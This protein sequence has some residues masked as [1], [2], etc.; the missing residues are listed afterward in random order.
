MAALQLN[1]VVEALYVFAGQAPEDLL[2]KAW[3]TA[4]RRF[5]RETRTW[6]ADLTAGSAIP[7]G[8]VAVAASYSDTEVIDLSSN[9]KYA[10]TELERMTLE[11]ARYRNFPSIGTPQA[12]RMAPTNGIY[13]LPAPNPS[14][15]ADASLLTNLRGVLSLTVSAT[16][17]DDSVRKYFEAIEYGTL[18]YVYRVPN[19][20][21]SDYKASNGYREMFQ[22]A[23][24][25]HASK[26]EDGDMLGVPR[27]VQYGGL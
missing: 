25:R 8:L 23:I 9:P 18:E 12:W 13:I 17:I 21:W 20:Q 14:G 16:T 19:Q 11:Q 2:I 6:R 4:A 5:F 15:I 27:K 3:R 1:D 22:D 7:G 10:G 26:G 24:D